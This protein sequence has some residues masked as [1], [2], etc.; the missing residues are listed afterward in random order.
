MVRLRSIA[1]TFF[2][3]LTVLIAISFLNF[4]SAQDG[5]ALFTANCASCHA[6][7]K[8][9]TGPALAGVEER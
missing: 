9:L 6:V 2:L 3:T 5:K 1:K 8:R 4:A 7:N